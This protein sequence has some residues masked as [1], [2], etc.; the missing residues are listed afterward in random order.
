MNKYKAIF[1]VPGELTIELEV[2]AENQQEGLVLAH[3]AIKLATAGQ[4][5][6]TQM[7]LQSAFNTSF[8]R[9]E[10]LAEPLEVLP[11]SP[12]S[13]GVEFTVLL[14]SQAKC[15]GEP[16]VRNSVSSY[17]NAKT[18]AESVLIEGWPFG[19]ASVLDQLGTKVLEVQAPRGGWETEVVM[20]NADGSVERYSWL[21]SFAAAKATALQ[22]LRR[23]GAQLVRI[24]D[25][26]DRKKGPVLMKEIR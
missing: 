16:A 5:R 22:L 25:Y 11:P 21:E 9:L 6:V 17:Q 1:S 20:A 24:T 8:D 12:L 19:S 23:E 7:N 2:S 18:L 4:A 3:D 15:A 14:F 10:T 13:L 26:T